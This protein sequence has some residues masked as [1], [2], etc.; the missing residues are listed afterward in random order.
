MG[1]DQ[2]D[3]QTPD[4]DA[5]VEPDPP[6]EALPEDQYMSPYCTIDDLKAAIPPRTLIELSND[7]PA[8]TEINDAI[9]IR[10]MRDASELADGYLRG[11]YT[12]PL[13]PVPTIVRN[14]VVDIARHWLYARRPEGYD[15]PEAV[16]RTYKA[17]LQTLEAIRSGVITLGMPETGKDIPEPGEMVVARRS[18]VFGDD[19]LER[20]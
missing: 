9:V 19:L 12:L 17:S 7:D 6:V 11:R 16:T 15:F 1:N 5:P 4:M 2:I 3:G 10:A 20:F 18:Q 13:D 14:L 8:A